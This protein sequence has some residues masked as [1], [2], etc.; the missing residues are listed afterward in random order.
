MNLIAPL[1]LASS[2]LSSS[3]AQEATATPVRPLSDAHS[4]LEGQVEKGIYNGACAI[5]EVDGKRVLERAVG[6]RDVAGEEPMTLD[7]IFRIYSMTKP[8]TAAAALILVD[9]G[10][11]DLDAPVEKY[12]PAFKDVQVA[13]EKDDDV[14]LVECERA[15]TVR[16]LCRHTSGLTYGFFGNSHVDQLVRRANVMGPKRTNETMGQALAE[17]PLKHQPGTR[18]EYS[19]SSDV[20]GRVIEVVSERSLGDFL[21]ERIFEPLGMV[22]TG[23][24]VPEDKRARVATCYRRVRGDLAEVGPRGAL[25][26]N[27]PVRHESGSGGLW[28]TA[29]DYVLFCRMLLGDGAVGDTRVLTEA[30][31]EEMLTDQ[32]GGMPAPMLRFKGGGFG[33]GLAVTKGARARG[34]P[35]GTVWWGGLAGTGFWIDPKNE[36]LG[37]FMIQNMNESLHANAFEYAVYRGIGR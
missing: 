36:T 28:S 7:T 18:F 33:L 37:V 25:D 9:E 35:E 13:V 22:D 23:F 34:A 24:R 15:M 3:F 12:L 4:H 11:L 31:V 16:D 19:L 6:Q 17:L 20:L 29:D 2:L 1:A 27:G 10:K 21:E 5:V 32:L 26:P 8:V 14:E 30:S